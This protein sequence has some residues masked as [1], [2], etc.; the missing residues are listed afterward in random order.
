MARI[1]DRGRFASSREAFMDHRASHLDMTEVFCDVDDFCQVFEPLLAQMLLP[2]VVGQS[3]PKKRLT[4]AL[5]VCHKNR[6]N[7]HKVFAG[8]AEWGKVQWAF[9]LDLSYI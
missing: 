9:I 1:T 8:L 5:K 2:E 4:F 3:R 7:S 6:A